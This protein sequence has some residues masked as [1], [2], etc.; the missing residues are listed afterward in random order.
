MLGSS[1]KISVFDLEETQHHSDYYIQ[2]ANVEYFSEE[3]GERAILKGYDLSEGSL[4]FAFLEQ[5][6]LRETYYHSVDMREI[7]LIKANEKDIENH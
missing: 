6:D 1:Q 5:A 3:K 4:R 2:G 7:Q